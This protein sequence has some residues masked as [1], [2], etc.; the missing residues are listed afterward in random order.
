MA[1]SLRSDGSEPWLDTNDGQLIP[2]HTGVSLRR[3]A[4]ESRPPGAQPDPECGRHLPCTV[5]VLGAASGPGVRDHAA[6]VDP[7]VALGR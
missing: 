7:R 5:G 1:L 6:V 3:R 2:A 4:A